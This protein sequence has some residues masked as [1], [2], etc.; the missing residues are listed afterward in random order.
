MGGTTS[1]G[2]TN[3][4][5]DIYNLVTNTKVTKTGALAAGPRTF[6]G[7]GT[8]GTYNA[9]RAVFMGGLSGP[10]TPSESIQTVGGPTSYTAAS[11]LSLATARGSGVCATFNSTLYG[12]V[13][14]VLFGGYV[15]STSSYQNALTLYNHRNNT[16]VELTAVLSVPRI[17]LAASV[18]EDGK[19]V[20]LSGGWNGTSLTAIDI[21]HTANVTLARTMQLNQA[22]AFHSSAALGPYVYIG[23]GI[24]LGMQVL[25]TRDWTIFNMEAL[26]NYSSYNTATQV[27]GIGVYFAGSTNG[28]ERINVYTCGNSV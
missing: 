19:Y 18:T 24:N 4:N 11:T 2:I 15:D 20:V 1:T 5:A 17:Q 7:I 10:T 12:G 21:Y 22:R 16:K 13:V 25:D 8:C 14:T 3:A 6:P 27:P 23:G 26:L 28:D 9:N